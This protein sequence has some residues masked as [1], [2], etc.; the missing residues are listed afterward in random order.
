MKTKSPF[1]LVRTG[2]RNLAIAL[3]SLLAAHAAQAAT[4]YWD[5]TATDWTAVGSWSTLGVH[6]KNLKNEL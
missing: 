2:S 1:Q 3:V 6:D 5:G 4:I